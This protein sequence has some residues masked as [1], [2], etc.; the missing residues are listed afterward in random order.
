[1]TFFKKIIP[2][3][4]AA[5]VFST[6][7]LSL[8]FYNQ[9]LYW[10]VFIILIISIAVLIL[11]NFRLNK[12]SAAFLVSPIIFLIG[13]LSFIY[14]LEKTLWQQIIIGISVV[15]YWL[16]VNNICT[17]LYRTKS[18]LSYS[19]ENISNYLNLLAIFFIYV[20]GFSFHILSI[21]RLRWLIAI[22]FL[23]TLLLSWQTI[24]INKMKKS[25]QYYSFILAFVVMEFYWCLLY[26]PT[27]FF[28]NGVMLTIVYYFAMTILKLQH[29][30]SLNKKS[31]LIYV[32]FCAVIITAV[33]ATA[34]WT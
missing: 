20:S 9:W 12:E 26:W 8:R 15:I 22:I 6:L 10:V 29:L 33:L 21:S 19:L 2:Y 4:S 7:E 25:W 17:Y 11:N 18:Y 24:W 14:F 31:I 16:F 23:T 5:L 30:Q 32:A 13:A 28:V 34:Q 1:M 27:S 3:L